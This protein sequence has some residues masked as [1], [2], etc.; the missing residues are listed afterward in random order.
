MNDQSKT[1][2]TPSFDDAIAF[3]GHACPGLAMGYRVAVAA[4]ARLCANRSEDEDLVTVVENDACSVD[5][6][7]LIC[8]CTFGKGNLIFQDHC[9][10]R[11]TPSSTE[12]PVG[13]S[14]STSK[15][16]RGMSQIRTSPRNPTRAMRDAGRWTGC[17]PCPRQNS[18]TSRRYRYR[19]PPRR[20]FIPPRVA[21]TVANA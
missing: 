8:G 21:P 10:S 2:P 3:H 16:P 14:A 6:V 15:R 12:Q 9:A 5:A 17:Y 20:A 4:M 19:L 1:K 18:C 7:Q 11:P 13:A